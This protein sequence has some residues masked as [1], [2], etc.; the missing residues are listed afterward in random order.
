MLQGEVNA[1]ALL[2]IIEQFL[3]SLVNL[4]VNVLGAILGFLDG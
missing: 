3:T 2:S 4:I 1:K